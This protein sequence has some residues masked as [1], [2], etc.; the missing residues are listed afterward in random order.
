MKKKT[1]RGISRD[2]KFLSNE[3]HEKAYAKRTGR[4]AKTYKKGK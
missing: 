3:A 4:K 1:K 2:R